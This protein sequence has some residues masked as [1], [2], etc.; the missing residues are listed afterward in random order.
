MGVNIRGKNYLKLL[1]YTSEEI[2]YLLDLS[3]NF[4]QMK[5]TGVSHRYLEGKNIVLLFEKTSTRTR[6]SFEVAG[7]DLGM[8]VTYL[9]PGSSQMGKKESIADTARVLGRMYDGIEY[10][11]F[12]Q[13]LVETLAKYAGVP[14]WNGLTDQFHPTQMLADLLTIEEKFGYLKGINFTFM[15]GKFANDCLCKNGIEF[16]SLCTKGIIS[17]RRIGKN[18][19]TDSRRKR[20]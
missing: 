2:R 4:K 1:D 8:G 20:M 6:C 17:S 12:D 9:D 13:E 3:K 11:G 18:S 14:V 5:R 15:G 7:M 19:K 10:R 16:Y